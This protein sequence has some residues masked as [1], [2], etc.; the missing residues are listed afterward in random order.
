MTKDESN[1]RVVHELAMR[2]DPY[3]ASLPL[4]WFIGRNVKMAFQSRTSRP[5]HMWVAITHIDGDYLIGTLNNIPSYVDGVSLGERVV[6]SRVW[7]EAVEQSFEE[8]MAELRNV[9]G[10]RDYSNVFLGYPDDNTGI[11]QG[12]ADRL[13]PRQALAR[14]QS[15]RPSTCE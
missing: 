1:I 15:Y 12:Y 14:W 7:I 13:T 9:R 2:P 6:V 3:Y 10:E 4:E 5:E 8:W 11:E